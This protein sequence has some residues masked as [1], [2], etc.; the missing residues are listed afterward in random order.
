MMAL[1]GSLFGLSDPQQQQ[2]PPAQQEGVI[3]TLG[4]LFGGA[5]PAARPT[6]QAGGE[7]FPNMDRLKAILNSGVLRQNQSIP[8]QP[9]ADASGQAA[10]AAAQMAS[11]G[12]TGLDMLK[13]LLTMGM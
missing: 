11:K 7:A 3:P 1:L 2:M 13:K 8:M 6:T 4:S 12:G 9:A 5:P 10:N